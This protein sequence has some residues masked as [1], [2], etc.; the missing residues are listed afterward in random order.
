[1]PKYPE[2][3]LRRDSLAFNRV[4]ERWDAAVSRMILADL[5]FR[6]LRDHLSVLTY[7]VRVLRL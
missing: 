7:R 2:I 3:R 4:G 5:S 6:T 1:M